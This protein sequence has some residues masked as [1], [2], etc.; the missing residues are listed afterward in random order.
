MAPGPAAKRKES[1]Q[2][3]H[4]QDAGRD[5][6]RVRHVNARSVLAQTSDKALNKDGDLDVPSFVKA[7]E[8]EIKA[9]EASMAVS[10]KALASRAFQELPKD[11]RRRTAS[12]NVKR[13]PKRMRARAQKEVNNVEQ[14]AL[15]RAWPTDI[16]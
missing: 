7:R 4:A 13:V 3:S 15:W 14:T 16:F 11:L 8:F 6:K 1:T 9:M 2:S 12:H 5:P 10:K